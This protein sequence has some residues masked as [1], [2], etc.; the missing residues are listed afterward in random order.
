[1]APGLATVAAA[2][3]VM[4]AL[5]VSVSDFPGL[6]PASRTAKAAAVKP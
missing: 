4:V 2:E 1:M 5:A 6:H 3:S